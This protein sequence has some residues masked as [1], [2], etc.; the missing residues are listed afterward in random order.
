MRCVGE[1]AR[2]G[3]DET[4]QQSVSEQEA[5]GSRRQ[6]RPSPPNTHTDARR[7]PCRRL[8]VDEDSEQQD[9]YTD[10]SYAREQF[11][12]DERVDA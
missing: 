4:L 5:G 12:P 7:Y 2:R 6:H 11:A 1:A 9:E 8:E 3:T 10:E